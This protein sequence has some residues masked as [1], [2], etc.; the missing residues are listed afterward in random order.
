MLSWYSHPDCRDYGKSGYTKSLENIKKLPLYHGGGGGV[1]QAIQN[2][3]PSGKWTN[4]GLEIA[5]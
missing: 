4:E 1:L 5:V 2:K 3:N